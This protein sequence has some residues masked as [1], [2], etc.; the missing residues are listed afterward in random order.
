MG[1]S[2]HRIL[3]FMMVVL[4]AACGTGVNGERY[5]GLSGSP[6]WRST[7]DPE[8]I[9]A[10]YEKKCSIYGYKTKTPDM[11]SCVERT[12]TNAEKSEKEAERERANQRAR[13]QKRRDKLQTI[14]TLIKK[15]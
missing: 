12:I 14:N 6:T 1:L 9:R 11:D 15:F 5:Y 8:T 2:M 10:Y 13:D 3:S 4:L 7:A